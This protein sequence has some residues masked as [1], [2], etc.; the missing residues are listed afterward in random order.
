[1]PKTD[2]G[3]GEATTIAAHDGLAHAI[4]PCHTIFDGDIAYAVALREGIPS[5]MAV[6]QMAT[7]AEVAVE[8][9][10]TDAVLA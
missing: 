8:R 3:L 4:R 2:V 5:A 9:A 10:V 6:L 7:A 1:M